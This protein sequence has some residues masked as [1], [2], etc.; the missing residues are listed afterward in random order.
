MTMKLVHYSTWYNSSQYFRCAGVTLEKTT[1]WGEMMTNI[2][3]YPYAPTAVQKWFLLLKPLHMD[4]KYFL[5]LSAFLNRK[6]I[7]SQPVMTTFFCNL[8]MGRTGAEEWSAR[9][10]HPA[11]FTSINMQ[12]G[13]KLRSVW[14]TKFLWIIIIAGI[15]EIPGGLNQMLNL[16]LHAVEA[17]KKLLLKVDN[18]SQLPLEVS[19][20]LTAELNNLELDEGGFALKC[21]VQTTSALVLQTQNQVQS[22]SKFCPHLC[23]SWQDKNSS[24][25]W[26]CSCR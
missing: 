5:L 4:W 11:D 13:H 19:P 3:Q 1:V 26:C 24:L 21:K 22:S 17:Q 7:Q 25:P 18:I 6:L 10:I 23:I 9:A 20:R 8:W 2:F 16:V 12:G 14:N 15:R